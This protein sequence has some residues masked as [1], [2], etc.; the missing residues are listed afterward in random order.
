MSYSKV[1]TMM[2]LPEGYSIQAQNFDMFLVN[3][4]GDVIRRI[5]ASDWELV[6]LAFAKG[7]EKALEEKLYD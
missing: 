4:K 1:T 5:T 2:D 3:Y 6:Q 7:T